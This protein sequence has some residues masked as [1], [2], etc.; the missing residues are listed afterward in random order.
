MTQSSGFMILQ[1]TCW[2]CGGAGQSITPC[3]ACKGQ[4]LKK[5]TKTMEV[6]IP[7]GVDDGT[8]VR[9]GSEGNS[10]KNKG[11]RG[12][13][14]VLC[15]VKPSEVFQRDGNDVH[16]NVDVPLQT[17]LLGGSVTVPTLNGK[18]DVKIKPGIQ[19]DHQ[20]LMRGK[21]IRDP[22]SGRIGHQY[23]HFLIKIPTKLTDKQKDL[24]KQFAECESISN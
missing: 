16:I 20:E 5:G 9:V 6:N 2:A 11:G 19:V 15:R 18:A 13:L 24:I 14:W 22:A 1:Q 12:H 3:R 23:L 17:A 7:A 10:G 21:G 8:R 4:G